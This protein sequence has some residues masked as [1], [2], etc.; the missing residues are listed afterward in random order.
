MAQWGQ[1][2]VCCGRG[3]GDYETRQDHCCVPGALRYFVHLAQVWLPTLRFFTANC[4]CRTYLS[5]QP[6]TQFQGARGD[7]G[8][9]GSW[10]WPFHPPPP[11]S[12]SLSHAKPLAAISWPPAGIKELKVSARYLDRYGG[13]VCEPNE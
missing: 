4:M 12:L 1:F 8:V 10:D 9:G 3:G 11:L 5:V 13:G 6:V 2:L 7:L